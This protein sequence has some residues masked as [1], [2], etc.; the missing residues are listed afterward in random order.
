MLFRTHIVFSLL[1]FLI[2][3]KYLNLDFYS[4]IIFGLF[5]FIGTIFVDID[6]TKSKIGHYWFFRP[7]QWV[8]SHRGMIHS[9]LFC[10]VLS[11]VVYLFNKNAGIGF[12]IGYLSHLFMDLITKEGICLFWPASSTKFSLFGIKV[13]GIIEEIMFVLLLLFDIFIVFKIII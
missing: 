6:S 11:L 3:F 9:L 10:L 1:I 5:L 4:K 12:L 13:G 8:F 2:F 7:I